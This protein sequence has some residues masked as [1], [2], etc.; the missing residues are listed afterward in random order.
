MSNPVSPASPARHPSGPS[1]VTPEFSLASG[2]SREPVMLAQP[3]FDRRNTPHPVTYHEF[4]LQLFDESAASYDR[5]AKNKPFIWE[6]DL[7]NFDIVKDGNGRQMVRFS[8]KDVPWAEVATMIT[9]LVDGRWSTIVVVSEKIEAAAG[10]RYGRNFMILPY[11]VSPD[12]GWP[13]LDRN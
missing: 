12:F 8:D 6:V 7:R 10:H 2:K 13:G 9:S 1:V 4:Q 11:R 3:V 5:M